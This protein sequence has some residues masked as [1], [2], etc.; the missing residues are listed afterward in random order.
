MSEAQK[1][2]G[3]EEMTEKTLGEWIEAL[4][5]G[6]YTQIQRDL[7]NKYGDCCLSVLCE[8]QKEKHPKPDEYTFSRLVPLSEQGLL[9]H[10]NDTGPFD[11]YQR[12]IND[13]KS[14]P[15]AYITRS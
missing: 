15:E 1:D 9:I 13:L 12:V 2:K 3:G 10:L 4:E 5:S 8:D 6:R 7:R 14:A 11:S